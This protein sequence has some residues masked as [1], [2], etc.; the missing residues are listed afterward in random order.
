MMQVDSYEA[1]ARGKAPFDS[2]MLHSMSIGASFIIDFWEQHYLN[3]FIKCGGSSIK[4]LIGWKGSGKTHTLLLMEERAK[5][6]GYLTAYIS[7][8][9]ILLND[10]KQLYLQILENVDI[11]ELVANMGKRIIHNLGYQE[12][13]IPS[14]KT[15]IGYLSDRNEFDGLMLRHLREALRKDFLENTSMD[16]NFAQIMS[17]LVSDYLGYPE[18][19]PKNKEFILSW[20]HGDTT[21]KLSAIKSL[22]ISPY[23]ITKYNARHM[24]RS[25]LE[26]ITNVGYSGLF[27]AIDDLDIMTSSSGL[28]KVHYTKMRRD[29]TYESIRQLIDEIDSLRHVMFVFAGRR[30][31]VDN[32]RTGFKSYQALWLRIQNEVVGNAVNRFAG[33]IDLDRVE[34]QTFTPN[35][36]VEMSRKLVDTV[37]RNLTA[38]A[39]N[40]DRA[41]D[42]L[43]QAR[44]GNVSI[45]LLVNRETLC[46]LQEKIEEVSDNV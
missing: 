34:R 2:V 9:S 43:A 8:E 33:I 4:F 24:L 6:K 45:P 14:G 44:M 21:Q 10:F 3:D 19:D 7:A 12:E 23:R 18:L 40:E 25:L 31:L 39:I 1:V 28:S 20:L 41:K 38:I 11:P 16:N 42:L 26:C 27:V 36:L 22:A 30:E 29:D 17:M 46:I 15:F 5:A 37:G 35:M 32:E 13:E